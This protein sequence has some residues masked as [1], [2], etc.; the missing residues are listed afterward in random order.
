[1]IDDALCLM[2]YKQ[3]M[4][5]I[6]FLNISETSTNFPPVITYKIRYPPDYVDC[7]FDHYVKF[8]YKT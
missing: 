5:G 7:K 1:M 6:V 3:Y 4:A 8:L 2:D